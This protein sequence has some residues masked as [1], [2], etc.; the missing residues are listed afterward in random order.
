[1]EILPAEKAHVAQSE[2]DEPTLFMVTASVLPSLKPEEELCTGDGS[3]P[4]TRGRALHRRWVLD[5][6]STN[7]MTGAKSAFSEL[8]SGIHGTVK[9]VEIEGYGTHPQGI[10]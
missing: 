6:G 8:D 2:E 1:M 3:S 9:F 4:Q 5:T 7:H 10:S